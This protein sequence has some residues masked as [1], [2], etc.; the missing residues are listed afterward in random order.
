LGPRSVEAT[1]IW[2]H[3]NLWPHSFES[4]WDLIHFT[5]R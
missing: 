5:L 2:H 4:I 1:F 3:I